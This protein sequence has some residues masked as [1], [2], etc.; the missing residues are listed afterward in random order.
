MTADI[1]REK[2]RE[3]CER[4]TK[5]PADPLVYDKQSGSRFFQDDA[6]DFYA[7][8]WRFFRSE[9]GAAF[10]NLIGAQAAKIA[11]LEAALKPFADRVYNDNG[12]VTVDRL[13]V[14]IEDFVAARKCLRK[15]SAPPVGDR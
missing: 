1:D 7:A 11:E 5:A 12:D 13:G 6:A 15:S 14:T 4:A 3:L 10:Q 9:S 8:C 2:L